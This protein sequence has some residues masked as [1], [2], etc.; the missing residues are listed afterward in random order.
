MRAF[1][2]FVMSERKSMYLFCAKNS[3]ENKTAKK[4]SGSQP[5]VKLGY[6]GHY[7]TPNICSFEP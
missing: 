2:T 1:L 3:I 7:G 5:T 6:N 4:G